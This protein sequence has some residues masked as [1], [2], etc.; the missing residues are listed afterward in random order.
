MSSASVAL[1]TQQHV[2]VVAAWH[3]AVSGRAERVLAVAYP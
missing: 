3:L 1:R 2:S